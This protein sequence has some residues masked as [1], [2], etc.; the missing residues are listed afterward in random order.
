MWGLG[1]ML[2]GKL[3]IYVKWMSDVG[4]E[5]E[6]LR[7]MSIRWILV[8]RENGSGKIGRNPEGHLSFTL[9]MI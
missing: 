7:R 4:I 6:K 2:L 8:L 1:E 3:V 5:G 9:K